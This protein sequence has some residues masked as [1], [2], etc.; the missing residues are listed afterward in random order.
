MSLKKIM[1]DK[2]IDCPRCWI[3]TKRMDLKTYGPKVVIDVCPKC[4]GIWLDEGELAKLIKNKKLTDDLTKDIGTKSES[5]LVCPRCG[6]LMDFEFADEIEVDVCLKCNGVWLDA[7]ELDNLK[8][9]SQQKFEGDK[10]EKAVEKWEDSVA[11]NRNSVFNRFIRK[12][13]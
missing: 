2:S 7:G 9:K 3:E 1:M 12:L 10:I 8:E 5:K 13:K 4:K 6:G 11:K